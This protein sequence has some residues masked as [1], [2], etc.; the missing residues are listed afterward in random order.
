MVW[1]I[2]FYCTDVYF[3]NRLKSDHLYITYVSGSKPIIQEG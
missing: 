3:T 1:N 2:L